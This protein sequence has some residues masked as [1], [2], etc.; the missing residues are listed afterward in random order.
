LRAF[1]FLRTTEQ[2]GL[3]VYSPGDSA[4][5]K[6]LGKSENWY[7]LTGDADV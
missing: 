1:G 4:H 3:R 6:A 5:A 7:F 2:S